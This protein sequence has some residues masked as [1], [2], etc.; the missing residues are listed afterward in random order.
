MATFPYLL[1]PIVKLPIIK[2]F[3][4]PHSEDRKGVGKIMKVFH[5]KHAQ[6]IVFDFDTAPRFSHK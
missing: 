3:A 4:L 2:R 1:D 6:G 5:T